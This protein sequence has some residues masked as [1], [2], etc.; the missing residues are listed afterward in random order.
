[1]DRRSFLAAGVMAGTIAVSGKITR[2]ETTEKS[3]NKAK[4]KLKYARV[5]ECSKISPVQTRLT[6]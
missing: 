3:S 6:S 5:Q 4:F 1:M 2:G